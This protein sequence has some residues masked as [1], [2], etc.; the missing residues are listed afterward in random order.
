MS[1]RPPAPLP[2]Y[3]K[4]GAFYLG[5]AYDLDQGRRDDLVLYD[6][7]DLTTHA[8]C[9]GM[10]GS[11]K[12]GLGVVLLEEAAL[13]GVPAI[14]IDPKGDMANLLLAFPS[15]T[16][17]DFAPWVDPE[18]AARAGV[19]VDEAARRAATR[20]RDGLADWNQDAA[21]VGRF[22][23]AAEA[24]VYTPGGSAARGLSPLGSFEAPP[25]TAGAEARRERMNAAAGG[26]LSLLG[27][28][29]DPLRSREHILLATLL[30]RAWEEGRRVDLP[31]L[32]RGVQTPPFQSVGMLDL[33]SF[34]PARDRTSFAGGL[35][36]L[37]ASPSFAAWLHGDPIDVQRLLWAPDGKPR[38]SIVSIA[39]LS[40]AE[41]MFFVTVLLG[42]TVGWMRAQ[43]GTSSLRAL[44]YMDEV[45]G[46]LPPTANPPSKT[47]LLTLLKQARA[48]GLGVVLATQNPV[49]LDYKA[50]S[51]AG[52]W[53]LGRLQT[54][55]DKARVL[56]GLEGASATS[57][58]AFDRSRMDATLA[59]LK[60]RVFVMHNVHED[61][62]AVF[63]TRWAL[64]Y[65]RGPLSRAQVQAL[66]S[67]RVDA[68]GGAAP[69]APGASASPVAGGGAPPPRSP[70]RPKRTSA[71]LPRAA[72]S[73]SISRRC[74]GSPRSTS[75]RRRPA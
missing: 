67:G 6:S 47:P 15:G 75:C 52:T 33:E 60:S 50:L 45:F 1:D 4:L 24:V 69:A 8:V 7:R 55:R 42:E 11:G 17:E 13:D 37:L 18:E 31:S 19:T 62:P 38:L 68:P 30:D 22:R 46:Y 9:V 26:L 5:R 34:F 28:E 23:A 32:V 3:E 14:V 53:F 27:M 20:H 59:R 74:S 12:T 63:E 21:R 2:A 16:P 73:P 40:D 49:D 51:N 65:L 61:A 43:S 70:R 36:N 35:N 64:S 48:F 58:A 29:A 57:G 41:R 66:T 72:R 44:L 25:A 56:D 10:T 39:H 54:E 71:S